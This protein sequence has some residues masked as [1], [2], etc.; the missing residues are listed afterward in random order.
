M[1]VELDHV[2][3]SNKGEKATTKK[4]QIGFSLHKA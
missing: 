3:T 4:K 2:H 1:Y